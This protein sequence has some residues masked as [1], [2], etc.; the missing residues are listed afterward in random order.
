MSQTPGSAQAEAPVA[1]P[2]SPTSKDKPIG[3][4]LGNEADMIET[5]NAPVDTTGLRRGVLDVEA[6]EAPGATVDGAKYLAADAVAVITARLSSS[7]AF[8]ERYGDLDGFFSVA[9]AKELAH[10]DAG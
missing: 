2:Q 5:Q 8:V 6:A 7:P 1:S 3:S 9:I 4:L 10:F